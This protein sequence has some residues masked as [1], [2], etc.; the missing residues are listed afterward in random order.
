MRRHRRQRNTGPGG[1]FE[2]PPGFGPGALFVRAP[3]RFDR[4]VL[5]G[6]AL[7]NAGPLCLMAG[8]VAAGLP[9]VYPVL[10]G[11]VFGPL[12]VRPALR[13]LRLMRVAR[14][15]PDAVGLDERG[16]LVR[17]EGRRAFQVPWSRVRRLDA[18]AGREAGWL[19]L[20]LVRDATVPEVDRLPGRRR[21]GEG[22]VLVVRFGDGAD[23]DELARAVRR[24]APAG[25]RVRL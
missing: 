21:T 17:C 23:R 19:R 7:R 5:A 24:F 18:G 22:A 4:A 3:Q 6:H 12:T 13:D 16:V 14:D 11:V 8:G 15:A 9:F 20:W 1:R 10:L 25:I 2:P